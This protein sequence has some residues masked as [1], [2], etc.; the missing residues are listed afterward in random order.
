MALGARAEQVRR[1]VVGQGAMIALL[2]IGIGTVAAFALT[3]LLDSMVFDVSVRDPLIFTV[4]P[5]ALAV[6]AFLAGYLPA[7]RAT[8]VDPVESL[9]RE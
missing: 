2:G 7:R 6:V 8:Q 9:R 1:I 5:L 3:R 4:V